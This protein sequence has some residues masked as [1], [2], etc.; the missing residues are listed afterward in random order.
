MHQHVNDGEIAYDP[1][2]PSDNPRSDIG[3]LLIDDGEIEIEFGD[4]VTYVN[5]G[6]DPD[7]E[8][9]VRITKRDTDL[10]QGIIAEHTPL[11]Q[12]L[13]GALI[14]DMVELRIPRI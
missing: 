6:V 1:T 2:A 12:A 9:G 7:R 4:F 13:L 3:Q 5:I 10:S 8:I 14:G 11:A